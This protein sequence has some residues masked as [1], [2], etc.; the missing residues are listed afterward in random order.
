MTWRR[1]DHCGVIEPACRS[2]PEIFTFSILWAVLQSHSSKE[3]K[4]FAYD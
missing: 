1:G 3:A 4:L 2:C